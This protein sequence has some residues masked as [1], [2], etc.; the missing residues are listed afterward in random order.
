MKA[1]P[2]A[3]CA[4]AS[5]LRRSLK[6]APVKRLYYES[7][8]QLRQHLADFVSA[9]NYARRLKTLRGLTSYEFICKTR[10]SQPERFRLNPLQQMP[11][12]N[13]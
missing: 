11:G 4:S 10:T 13:I 5:N 2:A 8:G 12:L 9:Y 3:F 6:D 7:H 1:N